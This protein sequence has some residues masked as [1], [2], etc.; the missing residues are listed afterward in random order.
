[1]IKNYP[2]KEIWICKFRRQWYVESS[3]FP[4]NTK[5]ELLTAIKFVFASTF[6]VIIKE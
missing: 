4:Y 1:M 6:E 5:E 2:K 3:L